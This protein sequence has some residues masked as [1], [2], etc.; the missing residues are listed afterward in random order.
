[1]SRNSRVPTNKDPFFGGLGLKNPTPQEGDVL[2]E[3]RL[4]PL[5]QVEPNPQQPRKRSSPE[6]DAELAADINWRGILQPILV[7]PH[8]DGR[9]NQFQIIAGER[10]WR[11]AKEAGLDEVPVIIKEVDDQEARLISLVE[12]LQR[13]DL[14]PTDEAQF[15]LKLSNE[16]NMSNRDIARMIN[17]SPGYVNERMR[18]IGQAEEPLPEA[19]RPGGARTTPVVSERPA[20]AAPKAWRYRPQNFERLRTY[21]SETIENWEQV[22]N[23]ESRQALAQDVA[24]LKE[25]LA[26]LEKKLHVKTRSR[27]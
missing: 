6:K 24:S 19:T 22:Q 26:R 9:E 2:K 23:E 20:P 8:P 25:E 5:K 21:I 12:N 27:G 13:L 16:Y 3:A 11:A 4:L 17:R 7:R 18:G 1:M 15:F 10:R 14:D